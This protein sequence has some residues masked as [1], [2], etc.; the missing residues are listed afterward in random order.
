LLPDIGKQMWYDNRYIAVDTSGL[1]CYV[2][3]ERGV[4]TRKK[5][6]NRNELLYWI[7]ESVT[8]SM[9]CHYELKNRAE[10]KDCRRIMFAKQEELLGMLSES[11]Q[12][13]TMQIHRQILEEH[14]FNDS[15]GKI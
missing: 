3:S 8:F 7:F 1:M 2:T 9:A 12:Q 13:K 5:T 14:P 4:E 6:N 11:W 10:D 15:T